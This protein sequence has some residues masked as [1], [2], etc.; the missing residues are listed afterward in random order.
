VSPAPQ[1]QIDLNVRGD[2]AIA[3]SSAAGEFS[4]VN[5]D[6]DNEDESAP[7]TSLDRQIQQKWRFKEQQA[8]GGGGKYEI[9]AAA[10]RRLL[11][12]QKEL[13]LKAYHQRSPLPPPW[14]LRPH[15]GLGL[16]EVAAPIASESFSSSSADGSPAALP[17]L[18][19]LV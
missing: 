3:G 11:R 15:P 19:G 9:E 12:P 10:E 5:E 8:D 16:I 1:V 14:L 13:W 2:S 6:K 17:P 18:F 7:A 4:D